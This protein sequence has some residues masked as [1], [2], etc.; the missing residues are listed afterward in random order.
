MNYNPNFGQTPWYKHRDPKP[1]KSYNPYTED[2]SVLKQ[3]CAENADKLAGAEKKEWE[4]TEAHMLRR[5]G[6][7]AILK[8]SSQNLLKG[9]ASTVSFILLVTLL[10]INSLASASSG[11]L[12]IIS[13]SYHNL[14]SFI[15]LFLQYALFFPPIFYIATVGKKN[16]TL[17]YF[18]KPKTNKFYIFRWIV[19]TF[20][21]TYGVAILFDVLFDLLKSLGLRVNDLSTPLPIGVTENIFYGLAVVVLAPV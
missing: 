17:T 7:D 6:E 9:L 20:G 4:S 5:I 10:A 14:F 13:K 12:E 11:F 2:D 16:K 19:I 15:L 21:V 3:I 18:K 8:N 1:E